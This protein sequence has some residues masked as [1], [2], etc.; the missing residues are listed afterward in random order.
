[1]RKYFAFTLL[2]SLVF[3]GISSIAQ[4]KDKLPSKYRKIQK[5]MDK[6]VESGLVGL[7]F[8]IDHPKYG[9]WTSQRGFANLETKE[10]VTEESVFYLGSISKNYTATIILQLKE[11]GLLSLDDKM[12]DYLPENVVRGFQYG[13]QVTILQLLNMTTGFPNFEYDEKTLEDYFAGKLD[14]SST[15][16]PEV[17]VQYIYGQPGNF[18]PGER[19]QYSSTNYI[20]LCMIMEVV[21]QRPH[22]ELFTSLFKEHGLTDSYYKNEQAP[23]KLLVEGHADED[24]DRNFENTSAQQKAY[25]DW[26]YGEDGVTST[27]SDMVRYFDLLLDGEII[28]EASLSEMKTLGTP[29]RPRY[30][31]GLM[32]DK[33][34]PYKYFI[35]HSGWGFGT[36]AN[37][38]YFP[39][40]DI[41]I[42]IF[43]NTAYRFG[44]E[45]IEKAHDKFLT[46][47]AKKL[48]LF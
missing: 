18:K 7:S 2:C 25:A 3:S 4:Q 24:D 16:P 28:T 17:L 26:S 35:G 1:M 48:F 13:D 14:L 44:G 39:E 27:M 23:S 10:Q 8:Y 33:G 11:Q 15:P 31:L 29:D 47:T 19:Y 12:S 36:Q 22:A 42:A 20:L 37:Y 30:G 9:Q 21:T 43:C 34:F 45:K 5:Y 38:M 40:Q 46:K 41:T 6:A 32:Y